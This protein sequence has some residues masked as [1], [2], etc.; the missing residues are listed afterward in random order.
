MTRCTSNPSFG[1][2]TA[3]TGNPSTGGTWYQGGQI[4]LDPFFDPGSNSPGSYAYWYVIAGEG[5]CPADS[6][7]LTVTL[8]QEVN[9]GCD[10][11]TS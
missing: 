2:F 8:F 1:L 11:D 4:L 7:L 6:A 3:L 10:G 5:D 9:A